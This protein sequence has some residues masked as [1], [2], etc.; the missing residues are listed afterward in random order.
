MDTPMTMS[1][2]WLVQ[3][4]M[5]PIDY[6]TI[7]FGGGY[8]NGGL[9]DEAFTILKGIWNFD[10]MGAAEF[11]FGAV[12][13]ALG[14]IAK[15]AE[16]KQLICG[17][18]KLHYKYA[19]WRTD[20]ES[21]GNERVYYLCPKEFESEIKKRLAKWAMSDRNDTKERIELNMSMSGKEASR[22]SYGWLELDNGFMFF[23]DEKMWRGSCD[24]FGVKTPSKKKVSKDD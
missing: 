15:T 20:E 16:D 24:M 12:P 4:L 8:K 2:T 3:R 19:D 1:R 9:S 21:E 17:S 5:K 14:N 23:T 6:R 10:Y 7:S 11:E 18:V 22:C 13:E